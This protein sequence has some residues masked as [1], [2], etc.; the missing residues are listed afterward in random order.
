MMIT[1]NARDF[2]RLSA[3][4][5]KEVLA[6]LAFNDGDAS[7]GKDHA[8]LAGEDLEM[9]FDG[10]M[11]RREPAVE[12]PANS[13]ESAQRVIQPPP[14]KELVD[15]SIEQ[16]RQLIANV[17]ELSKKTLRL[18]ASRQSV[19]LE[20]LIGP[21]A[22]YAD[23]QLL[24]KSLVG[25]VN[26]RLRTVTRNRAA[27]LLV[28]D[29]SKSYIGLRPVSA[30]ALRQALDVQEPIPLIKYFNLE[31]FQLDA[32]LPGTLAFFAFVETAWCD[33]TLRPPLGSADVSASQISEHLINHGFKPIGG[34]YVVEENEGQIGRI[35]YLPELDARE[36][37]RDKD[38]FSNYDEPIT[39]ESI[40]IL[41][42]H[43]AAPGVFGSVG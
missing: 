21:N 7:S 1:L 8:R 43:P 40:R 2:N 11:D 28:G 15:I 12:N 31:G 24:K 33:F 34:R 36:F 20:V 6:L 29:L 27:V 25:A 42:S 16:A 39:A 26:R 23:Y 3:S 41:L 37:I 30:A 5:Q 22:D 17:G 18:L 4:C 35:E 9:N 38:G 13:G 14:K 19:S 32:E 10:V